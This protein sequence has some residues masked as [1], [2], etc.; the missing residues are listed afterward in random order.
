MWGTGPQVIQDF[1]DMLQQDEA[2]KEKAK[3][4]NNAKSS[5]HP[6]TPQNIFGLVRHR[7]K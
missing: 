6:R 2:K 1:L 4:N 7:P 5:T 3:K